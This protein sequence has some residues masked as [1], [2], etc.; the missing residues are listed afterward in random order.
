MSNGNICPDCKGRGR[1]ES[2]DTESGRIVI[3]DCENDRCEGGTI[4]IEQKRNRAKFKK[5]RKT[6]KKWS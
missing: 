5:Q 1:H 2:M 4:P 3:V 6:K